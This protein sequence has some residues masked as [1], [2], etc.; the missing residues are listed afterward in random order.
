MTLLLYPDLEIGA[1]SDPGRKRRDAPNED[2]FLVLPAEGQRPPVMIVAD[3]MGGHVGGS[4]ASRLVTQA[5][6]DHFCQEWDALLQSSDQNTLRA[7]LPDLLGECLLAAHRALG[8][9]ARQHPE[10][11][12]MG[13]TAVM[14]VIVGETVYVANVGDSRAYR[15]T[16]PLKG[17]E[18]MGTATTR[19]GWWSRLWSGGG[20]RSS[21]RSS[22]VLQQLSYDHSIVAEQVRA[23]LITPLEALRSPKRNRLTQ[24]ITPARSELTPYTAQA[25]FGPQDVLLLCTDGLWGVVSEAVIAAVLQELPPQVAAQKLVDLTLARGAPDNVTVIVARWRGVSVADNEEKTN[26]GLG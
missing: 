11:A 13:S 8:E 14:A 23:G 10:M 20:A 22:P 24:S 2:A 26:P 4:E 19:R 1:M 16:D 5:A 6:A 25:D 3:G 18:A 7:R 21:P 12:S 9:H 15:L 17:G